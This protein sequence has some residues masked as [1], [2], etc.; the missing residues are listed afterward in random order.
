LEP[1]LI[2]MFI[3]FPSKKLMFFLVQKYAKETRGPK[4]SIIFFSET[5]PTI[6]TKLGRNIYWMVL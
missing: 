6:T 2:G 3:R 5:T 4:M 1:N